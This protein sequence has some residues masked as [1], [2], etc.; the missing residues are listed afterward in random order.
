MTNGP[1]QDVGYRAAMSKWDQHGMDDKIQ[2]IL[3]SVQT[4]LLGEGPH[5]FGRPFTSAYQIAIAMQRSHPE[6]VEEIDKPIGGRG[7][8][9]EDTLAQYIAVQLSQRIKSAGPGHAIEGA[10]LSNADAVDVTFRRPDG[11]TLTSSLTSS[12][13]HMAVFRTRPPH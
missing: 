11:S 12:G 10:F 5:H 7:A 3:E 9:Q 1:T 6:T 4:P 13:H 2:A 8:G